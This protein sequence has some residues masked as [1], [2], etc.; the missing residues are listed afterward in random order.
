[1]EGQNHLQQDNLNTHKEMYIFH[2]KLLDIQ[3]ALQMGL[4]RRYHKV[5]TKFQCLSTG[6][7]FIT[8]V[9]EPSS[10][11]LA[12]RVIEVCCKKHTLTVSPRKTVD[13]L[14]QE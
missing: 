10:R 14:Q 3:F 1:M 11:Q 8:F 9:I 7:C 13:T 5:T 4:I 2:D 6:R 12:L